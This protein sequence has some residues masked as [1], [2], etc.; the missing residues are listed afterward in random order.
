[1]SNF[2]KFLSVKIRISSKLSVKQDQDHSL[3][4]LYMPELDVQKNGHFSF[5]LI[6]RANW[7]LSG[8]LTLVLILNRSAQCNDTLF[9]VISTDT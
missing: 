4:Q 6:S 2:M 3:N 9:G 8:P 7:R 5:F 1:M